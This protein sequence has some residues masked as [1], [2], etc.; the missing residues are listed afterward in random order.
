MTFLTPSIGIAAASIAIPA[1]LLLYFLK[2]RRRP[3]R[4]STVRFWVGSADDLQVNAPFRMVRPSWLL[5]LHLLCAGLLCTAAARPVLDK[6]ALASGRVILLIDHS[7]SMSAVDAEAEKAGLPAVSRL[8]A[9]KREAMK[10]IDGLDAGGAQAMVVSVASRAVARENFTRDAGALRKAV[11]SIEATDQPGDLTGALK[12][13]GAFARSGSSSEG[14]GGS[15]GAGGSEVAP[16]VVLISDGALEVDSAQTVSGIGAL[17]TRLVRVGPKPGDEAGNVGIVAMSAR[18]D[19]QDPALLRVFVR[20]QST[21]PGAASVSVS[22]GIEGMARQS[23]VVEIAGAG[24]GNAPAPQPP[25]EVSRTFEFRTVDGGVLTASIGRRD[26]LASDN[27]AALVVSPAKKPR[28]VLVRPGGETTGAD[29][30]LRAALETLEPLSL[31]VVASDRYRRESAAMND[32]ADLIVFDRVRPEALPGRTPT[33][34]FAAGLPVE[35]LRVGAPGDGSGG[36]TQWDRAHPVMRYVALGDVALDGAREVVATNLPAGWSAVPLAWARQGPVVVLIERAGV[37]RLVVGVDLASTTW[38]R[39]VSF[40]TFVANAVDYLTLRGDENTAR[41]WRTNEAVAV[42][43]P[44]GSKAG[45]VFAVT[46]PDAEPSIGRVGDAVV[47]DDAGMM[48]GVLARAGVYRV[49]AA[50]GDVALPVNLFDAFESEART[51]DSVE[52]GGRAASADPGAAVGAVEIWTWFVVGA[53]V[54]LCLEWFVF[55]WKSRV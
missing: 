1:V 35:G 21:L 8:A 18:R 10:V 47:S 19:F 54:L 50:G 44:V 53:L 49:G 55:A 13:V 30:N 51:R 46:V 20:I 3:V 32:G 38:S 34:S 27:E 24:A 42:P 48:V 33:I 11:E 37:R 6:G 45:D 41:S 9:A 17:T 29:E 2:L 14:A 15:G 39:E 26:V 52:I 4:V 28:L 36:F 40:P 5:L 43:A 31:T 25:V 23:T 22:C 16:T 7:A 12:L